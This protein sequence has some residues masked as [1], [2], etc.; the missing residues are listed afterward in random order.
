MDS[1]IN[2]LFADAA[3]CA[4][5]ATAQEKD[6]QVKKPRWC[7]ALPGNKYVEELL[8]SSHPARIKHVLRMELHTFYT[9]RDWLLANTH[10]KPSRTM[11]VEEKL[12][13][14]LHLTTRPAS[15]RDTQERF[16]HSGETISWYL[17]SISLYAKLIVRVVVSMRF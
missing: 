5:F 7:T 16:S 6:A 14:F 2:D 10:L 17:N 15:N 11:T 4:V 8:Q 3:F 9:L 13:V 12:V 1:D